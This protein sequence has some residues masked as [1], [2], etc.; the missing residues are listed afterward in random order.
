MGVDHMGTARH[1]SRRTFLA[2]ASSVALLAACGQSPSGAS[3]PSASPSASG[4]W[5]AQWDSWIA[6]ARKEGKLVLAS[7]PSPDAR[8]QVP[9]AFKKAF[10]VEI[11]YL[12]GSTSDLSNRLRSEQA[13]N[14][15][16]VDV[17]V[18]GA[19]TAYLVLYGE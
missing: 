12:G 7:G 9:A 6:G 2:A 15:Y 13:A 14:Q 1:I 16:T 11:E 19:D 3:K 8:V 5:Q 17:V 18:A 4:G 10:G